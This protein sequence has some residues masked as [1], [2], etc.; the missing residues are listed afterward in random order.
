MIEKN[1]LTTQISFP[2]G[3]ESDLFTAALSSALIHALGYTEDTPYWC[4]PRESYCI[5][6]SPCGDKPL[7]KH[8]E[9]IYHC[10][11][12]ATGLAFGF[13][14]PWDDSV[15]PHSLPGYRNGWRWDNDYIDFVMRFAG[16]TWKS[17]DKSTDKRDIL[18]TVTLAID[19]GFP[20]LARLQGEFDWQIVTGY[21]GDTL[22]GLEAHE[23]RLKPIHGMIRSLT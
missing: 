17:F 5:H 18:K 9:T 19:N 1:S 13:E 3:A 7:N 20:A 15:E 21:D 8:Q 2:I 10:L 11:L 22:L 4:P 12:A 23:K 6:C 14:Y 16:V